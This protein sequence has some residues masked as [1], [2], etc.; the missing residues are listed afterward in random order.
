MLFFNKFVNKISFP[1]IAKRDGMANLF[2][3]LNQ[4][5]KSQYWSEIKILEYQFIQIKKLLIHAYQ[6][7]EFYKNRFDNID[8]NPFAFRDL[9]ELE[10]IPPLTKN[11]IKFNLD[12]MVANNFAENEIHRDATGGSTGSHTPF[13]RNNS[14]LALK[15]AIELRCNRWA[16]WK[17]GDK[18]A[19][20][21][22]AIQ[23][24]NKK[25][26]LKSRIKNT[27]S[28]RA[29]MLYSGSLNEE[30]LEGH[31]RELALFKPPVIRAFPNPLSILANYIKKTNKE[32]IYIP[33]IISVGEP[34][35]ESHRKLFMDVFR[36]NVF[37]CYVSRECGNM[38]CE[39]KE[40][41]RLHINAEMV[42][43]EFAKGKNKDREPKKMLI[44][45]LA[46]YGMPFIR[47]QIEDM[48]TPVKK[49]CSC[50]RNLP[51]I[52]MDAGRSSDFLLSPFDKSKISGCS[53]L[54]YMIA[55]GPEVGQVQVIQDKLDHII[56][57]IVK[58]NNFS[59]EKLIHFD[60]IIKDVF[61]G[62][63]NY[64]IEY[65]DKIDHEKSNKYMFT[66]CLVNQ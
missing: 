22:P 24:I 48:G 9:N 36:S 3:K 46:N 63:M 41:K 33:S 37:N 10:G 20:Y 17:V 23:D 18:I 12:K 45:D 28:S 34:L 29:L 50:G 53:F 42:Y 38:A 64:N 65:P 1:L 35:L 6:H 16:G 13:Y 26:S 49:R 60:K 43:I 58:S 59:E 56:L 21:W 14:C 27:L 40:H 32:R 39:C 54:H 66:K 7:T 51:L 55:E 19:F 25:Q 15:K 47:Y 57:K 11:D 61:H 62:E 8:F 44:T 5:E 30:V 52:S 4:F 2:Y 31:Y